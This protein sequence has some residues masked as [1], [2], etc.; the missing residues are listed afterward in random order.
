MAIRRPAASLSAAEA[1][2]IALAAQGFGRT[3]NTRSPGLAA[4]TASVGR[5]GVVQIDSVNAVVRSHYLPLFSRLGPYERTHL[6]AAAY[7]RR[8]LFEYWG[9]EASLLPVELPAAAALAHAALPR[10][11]RSGQV[12]RA[13]QLA[14][15]EVER[16]RPEYVQGILDE[17]TEPAGSRRATRSPGSAEARGGAGPTARSPSSTCSPRAS[18]PSPHGA[19]SPASTT[20]PSGC[21]QRRSWRRR[22]PIPPMPNVSCCTARPAPLGSPRCAIW[23]TTTASTCP[24]AGSRARAGRGRVARRGGR[25][26]VERTGVPR[27]GSP[28]AE[29]GRRPGAAVAVRLPGLGAGAPNASG[30]S[31]IA[32]RSTR[33]S[34][35]RL[36]L[37][38]AAVPVGRA[39]RRP[40]RRAAPTAPPACSGC[41][42]PSPTPNCRRG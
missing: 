14:R 33:P 37:L 6:D 5:L 39:S 3:R 38:R 32:S 13:G 41:P 8:S 20:C 29:E 28:S 36:R 15:R 10:R 18:W 19:T 31:A 11:C 12:Q 34:P 4:L 16:E 2:R 30:A 24:R 35:T 7:R 27:P 26:R 22:R 21:F 17:V 42:A 25:G 1:R 23:P 40:G 9:H